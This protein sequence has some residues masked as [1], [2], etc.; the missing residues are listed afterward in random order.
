[1]SSNPPRF[2]LKSAPLWAALLA[3]PLGGCGFSPLYGQS[4]DPASESTVA[5]QL[6][7]VAVQNIP[8]RTGQLLRLSLETQ[9]HAA[10]APTEELYSLAVG[11]QISANGI[12]VQEDTSVTRNRFTATANW[13]LMPIGGATPLIHGIATTENAANIID[14]QYF[15]LD[16][17]TDTINQQLADAIAG[18]ITAQIAAYFKTHPG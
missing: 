17:E 9:L 16:L 7:T 14:E 8:D 13:S 2:F 6:D 10:G 12:G 4:A 1:L 18:Q 15:A 5:Q 3:A 11:Y